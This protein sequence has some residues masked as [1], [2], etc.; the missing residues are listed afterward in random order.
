MLRNSVFILLLTLA[1]PLY[2]QDAGL[3]VIFTPQPLDPEETINTLPLLEEPVAPVTPASLINPSASELPIAELDL[4]I[5]RYQ[6]QADLLIAEGGAYNAALTE[7]LIALG[8]A[9]RQLGNHE[10]ALDVFEQAFHI[11]RIHGGLFNDGQI[12]IIKHIT[13]T[14]V[15]MGDFSLAH[16]R[17]DYL[18]Y[19]RYKLHPTDSQANLEALLELAGWS[20]GVA[21]LAYER[22]FT[23]SLTFQFNR[24]IESSRYFGNVANYLQNFAPTD[25]RLPDIQLSRALSNYHL[26]RLST[27]FDSSMAAKISPDFRSTSPI[28]SQHYT[29]IG[30]GYSQN[31]GSNYSTT[32]SNYRASAYNNGLEALQHRLD[33]L[34][35]HASGIEAIRASVDLADWYLAFQR[36]NDAQAAYQEALEMWEQA[37]LDEVQKLSLYDELYYPATPRSIPSTSNPWIGKYSKP[38]GYHGYIDIAFNVSRFGTTQRVQ[39][40]GNSEGTSDALIRELR[41]RIDNGVFRPRFLDGEVLNNDAYSLRFY[42]TLVYDTAEQLILDGIFSE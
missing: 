34:R 15:D 1:T 17:Q 22:D 26:A 11:T 2:G 25:E 18:Y 6:E 20:L 23:E 24:L 8:E 10:A 31:L 37:D 41:T 14:L 21:S 4:T 9:Q 30:T 28:I 38:S 16:D 13:R 39:V 3:R 27:F 42:Y 33:Y 32:L 19:L 29:D 40:T 36:R 5:T 35:E 7:N 12:P